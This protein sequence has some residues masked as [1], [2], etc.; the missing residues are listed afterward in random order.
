MRASLGVAPVK[1]C[2]PFAVPFLRCSYWEGTRGVRPRAW[3]Y[4]MWGVGVVWLELIMATPQV[5]GPS[6]IRRQAALAYHARSILH[7]TWASN[8]Y[9]VRYM[10]GNLA[11]FPRALP[12]FYNLRASVR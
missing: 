11:L 8:P 7:F 5:R 10:V 6:S 3:T 12:P 9:P 2:P 1:P 4:D